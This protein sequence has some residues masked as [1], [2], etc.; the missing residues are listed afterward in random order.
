MILARVAGSVVSTIKSPELEGR[1]L[2]L[3]Q[4]IDLDGT[5]LGKDMVAV[6]TVG[7]GPGDRVLM[8]KEGGSARL[9][10]KNPQVP[11]Q[12][13]IVAV[14]DSLEVAEVEGAR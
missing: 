8:F 10:L 7:A 4:P 9:L 13:V 2:L 6:D 1:R 3:V 5:D 12:L 11:L 14:V